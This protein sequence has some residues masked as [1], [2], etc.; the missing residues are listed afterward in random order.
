MLLVLWAAQRVGHEVTE[1]NAAASD[2]N[3]TASAAD[4][5]AAII[6]ATIAAMSVCTAAAITVAA[7]WSCEFVYY[8][9]CCCPKH[10]VYR[11]QL[12]FAHTIHCY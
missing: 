11:G 3:V 8:S 7:V 5:V 4:D 6:T 9:C 1:I 10:V 2:H 12:Y